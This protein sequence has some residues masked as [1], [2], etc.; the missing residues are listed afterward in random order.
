MPNRYKLLIVLVFSIFMWDCND[1]EVNEPAEIPLNTLFKS[2]AAI[3][4]SITAGFQSGS[5][6]ESAQLYSY[7][8]LIAG[9]VNTKFEQPL[10][11]DPGSKGRMELAGTTGSGFPVISFNQSE[12]TIKNRQYPEPYN[13]L[14]IPGA[15]LYD[16]LNATS[17]KNCYSGLFGSPN[18]A[19]DEILR[20]D[21]LNI[22]SQ[23]HQAKKLNPTFITLWIG[24]NDIL[25]HASS[26]GT[27]PFTPE[28]IFSPLYK[29]LIDSL[30]KIPD[31]KVV[32]ANIPDITSIPYFTTVGN[33]L[34]QMGYTSV[35]GIGPNGDTTYLS[36]DKNYLTLEAATL[37]ISETGSLTSIGTTRTEPLPDWVILDEEETAIVQEVIGQYNQIIAENVSSKNFGLVDINAFFKA[38]KAADQSGGIVIDGI[39]FK[40][41]YITGELFSLDGVHPTSRAQGLIANEFIKVIN[42]KYKTSIP[43]INV[44]T[45]PNSIITGTIKLSKDGLPVFPKG[46]FRRPVF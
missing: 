40:T 17:S 44:S 1:S 30:N 25:G 43:L 8:N 20:N 45:I 28:F 37:L 4:N 27:I 14:G 38:F 22:G 21:L 34:I 15:A 39:T 13:N 2:Y 26:G 31:I 35:W 9:Q 12:G 11:S 33:K 5:L 10:V 23:F 29:D 24:N 32:A 7:G 18:R 46:E 3:G 16:I 41:D 6:F 42:S 36:L 19:F